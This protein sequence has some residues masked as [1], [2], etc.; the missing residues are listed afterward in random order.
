MQALEREF[1]GE[2]YAEGVNK[3]YFAL[4]G[5]D[6]AALASSDLSH[7]PE[8]P[9]LSKEPPP[10][11]D[12]AYRTVDMSPSHGRARILDR[13]FPDGNVLEIGRNLRREDGTLKAYTSTFLGVFAAM[14]ALGS[15]AGWLL[16]RK[17]MAGV[18]R[19]GDTATHVGR[20]DFSRRVPPGNE[21]EEIDNLALAFNDMLDKIQSLILDLKMVTDDIAHDLRTPPHPDTRHGGGHGGRQT[22]PPR[23]P[24]LGGR[25][26]WRSA[27]AWSR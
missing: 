25:G 8:I 1:K 4:R 22:K 11:A 3:I 9:Q 19:I 12:G 5:R 21:G 6:G 2:A 17:F 20:G 26:P 18:E 14:L 27:T 23:L 15:V 13:P 16:A 7:W 24:G 10:P